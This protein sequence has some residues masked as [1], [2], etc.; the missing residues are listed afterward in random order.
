MTPCASRLRIR[1]DTVFVLVT[2]SLGEH[3]YKAVV[4]LELAYQFRSRM[5]AVSIDEARGTFDL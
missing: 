4:P 2:V 1:L 5:R 3:E